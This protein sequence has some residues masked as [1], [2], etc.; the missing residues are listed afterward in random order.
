MFILAVSYYYVYICL[1]YIPGPLEPPVVVVM[2]AAPA[3]GSS[4]VILPTSLSDVPVV[5]WPTQVL[6]VR[7]VL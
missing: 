2:A 5:E 1:V 7:V 3:L 6:L 4:V